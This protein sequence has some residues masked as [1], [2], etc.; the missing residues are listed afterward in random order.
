MTDHPLAFVDVETTGLDARIHQPWEVSIWLEE[1]PAP[2]TTQVRHTLDHADPRALEI[3]GYWNR[4]GSL[5]VD[6]GTRPAHIAN[7]LRGRTLVAANPAFDAA[8]LTR[9]I[10]APVWHY[11][12]IDVSAGVMWLLGW[13]RPRSLLDTCAALRDRGFTIPEPDHTAQGDVR[14]VRAVYDALRDLAPDRA[15]AAA[16]IEAADAAADAG[17]DQPGSW[18]ERLADAALGSTGA[19]R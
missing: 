12:L 19:P 8:F 13:D 14:A 4:C 10:G 9:L 17:D 15:R 5:G 7:P 16:A 18:S 6:T 3:G 1:D 11:R 2:W